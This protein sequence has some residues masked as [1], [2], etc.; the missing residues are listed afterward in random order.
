[1]EEESKSANKDYYV[2]ARIPYL[3]IDRDID[4]KVE[5]AGEAQ[6]RMVG[7]LEDA[8]KEYIDVGVAGKECPQC[9]EVNTDVVEVDGVCTAALAVETTVYNAEG[10]EH[11]LDVLATELD[12][13]MKLRSMD[14][15]TVEE[16]ENEESGEKIES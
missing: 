4:G 12:E 16:I 14:V 5:A 11:A 13:V 6:S 10:G 8:G 3:F 9:P 15:K 1:M 2:Q 7:K